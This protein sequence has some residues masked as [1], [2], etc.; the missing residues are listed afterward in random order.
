MA[1][2][3]VEEPH[4]YR[5][6]VERVAIV[7]GS[8]S[9]KSTLAT[10][11][12]D[13]L[14]AEHVELDALFHRPNW[15]PTP[16]PEFRVKVTAALDTDRWVVAGNYSTVMDIVHGNADTIVWLDLPRWMVTLRVVR[17][18]LGRVIRRRNSGTATARDGAT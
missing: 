4:W 16:T 13:R 9:G 15:E 3:R 10:R 12:A 18:S 7:G 5:R 11:L 1:P 6:F 2:T 17:R 14:D 8:G